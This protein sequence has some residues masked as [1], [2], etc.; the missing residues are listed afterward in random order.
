MFQEL[1]PLLAQRILL[2]TLSRVGD[3]QICVNVIPKSLK[4]NQ[5][6]DDAALTTPLSV[7]GVPKE[8]DEQLPRQ[9]AEFVEAHLGLSSTLKIAKEQMDAAAKAAREAAKKSTTSKSHAGPS[10]S[11]D[12]PQSNAEPTQAT[13]TEAVGAGASTGSL[14]DLEPKNDK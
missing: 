6:D 1:M 8:L 12:E 3:E 13:A 4:S 9:L 7:T 2:L 11:A 5:Q 14:F 10:R